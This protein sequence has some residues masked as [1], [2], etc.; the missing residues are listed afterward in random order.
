MMEPFYSSKYSIAHAKRRI[1]ELEGEI[2][3]Y[4]KSDPYT[5]IV[6]SNT[7]PGK[8]IHK[9]KLT[10][11]MPA[12]ILGITFDALN[13]L[14][15]ALDQSGYAVAIAARKT[16]KNAHF[17]FGDNVTEVDD[18]KKRRSKNIPTEI[19]DLML[20]FKPYLGGNDLLWALNKMCNANKHEIIIPIII[21]HTSVTATTNDERVAIQMRLGS[22][23]WSSVE[24]SSVAGGVRMT[25]TPKGLPF[26]SSI[27]LGDDEVEAFS[28]PSGQ[29]SE[30]DLRFT[31]FVG[32]TKIDVVS[33]KPIDAL[34][35]DFANI[36]ESVVA[37]IEAEAKRIGL[38]N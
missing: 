23:A 31:F 15:S 22:R 18:C 3:S 34:L 4:I 25:V 16:G 14:R 37:G 35:N 17:P 6:D 29:R 8:D 27:T 13:N 5:C 32:V 10:K 33:G 21:Q 2:S 7:E 24:A 9:I 28:V 36:V 1:R 12:A 30:Y 19:F 38:V 26:T 20:G 11:P